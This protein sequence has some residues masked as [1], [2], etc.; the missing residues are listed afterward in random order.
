[1]FDLNKVFRYNQQRFSAGGALRRE[2]RGALGY[3]GVRP[4]STL[5][6]DLNRPI[7]D[8]THRYLGPLPPPEGGCAPTMAQPRS[9]STH[10][11]AR[12]T[13]GSN[14]S[15]PTQRTREA[16]SASSMHTLSF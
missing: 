2:D 3:S 13:A 12:M 7:F 10:P 5:V 14:P 9:S 1:M 15:A 8:Q 11:T 6:T 4:R 16:V